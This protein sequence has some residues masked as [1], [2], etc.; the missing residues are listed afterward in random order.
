MFAAASDEEAMAIIDLIAVKKNYAQVFFDAISAFSQ[1]DE[2]ELIFIVPPTEYQE[3]IFNE[4]G[5]EIV[6]QSLNMMYGRRNAAKSWQEH[7]ANILTDD[8]KVNGEF[9]QNPKSPSQYHSR[10]LDVTLDLHV[11]DG[12]ATGPDDALL[13]VFHDRLPNFIN[14]KVSPLLKIGM[15][16]DH[17]GATRT[18]TEEGLVILPFVKYINESLAVMKMENCKS[19]T[20]PKLDQQSLPGDDQDIEDAAAYR[21]VTCKQIY[22]AKQRPDCQSTVRWLCKR[23]QKPNA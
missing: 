2:E 15:S 5:E 12:G 21:T 11:D 22:F 14:L 18:R 4:T 6:W 17:L 13:Q 16:F 10:I 1:A 19:S 7:F 3:K 23:L 8:K 20:S 9:K